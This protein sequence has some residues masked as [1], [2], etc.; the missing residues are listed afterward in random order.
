M[1]CLSSCAVCSSIN[2]AP[3]TDD[4]EILSEDDENDDDDDD[5]DNHEGSP[6]TNED[7]NDSLDIPSGKE[8]SN[9][10]WNYH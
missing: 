5:G 1:G 8:I 6:L 4:T 10:R 7:S 3:V 9:A 2:G